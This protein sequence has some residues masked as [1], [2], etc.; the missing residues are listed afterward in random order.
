MV[1]ISIGISQ[2]DPLTQQ[3]I[4]SGLKDA[5]RAKHALG[6][7]SQKRMI[8]AA[9]RLA[10]AR[11]LHTANN[12]QTLVVDQDQWVRFM[13]VYGQRCWADPDFAKWVMKQEIHKDMVVK[14]TGTKI[15]SGYTGRGDT[16]PKPPKKASE[17]LVAAGKY[18]RLTETA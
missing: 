10:E 2:L 5:D 4:I 13:I 14:D 18:A 17:G 11:Q 9:N 8:A 6:L 3:R 16:A 7:I 12:R 1:D 15:Q